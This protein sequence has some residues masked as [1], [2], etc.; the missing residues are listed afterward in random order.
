MEQ[1]QVFKVSKDDLNGLNVSN[2]DLCH[3]MI[4][5]GNKS[6]FISELDYY[7]SV[8]ISTKSISNNVADKLLKA[9]H[10]VE[11]IHRAFFFKTSNIMWNHDILFDELDELG[12]EDLDEIVEIKI[13]DNVVS[14][15]MK[16][17][18]EIEWTH[19]NL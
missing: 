3:E 18:P 13:E 12:L 15:T 10:N 1:Q 19:I 4:D 16:D 5:K 14:F 8:L 17:Y 6:Y 9:M 7:N 11:E 2:L